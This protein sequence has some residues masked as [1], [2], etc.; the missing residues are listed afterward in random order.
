MPDAYKG[1]IMNLDLK[2]KLHFWVYLY[3]IPVVL[4]SL[5]IPLIFLTDLWPIM[6]IPGLL[7]LLGSLSLS[8]SFLKG[9]SLRFTKDGMEYSR[10]WYKGSISYASIRCVYRITAQGKDTVMI[11][12]T[13]RTGPVVLNRRFIVDQSFSTQDR[14]SIFRRITANGKNR[15]RVEKDS[16]LSQI[17]AERSSLGW[18]SV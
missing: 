5:T 2:G 13:K 12:F 17:R 4:L 15:F 9:H 7:S 6:L 18:S 8:G 10:G 1:S 11:V 16:S 3:L 14:A